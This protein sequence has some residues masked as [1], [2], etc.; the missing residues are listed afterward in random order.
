[1]KKERQDNGH[2][3]KDKQQSTNTTQKIKDRIFKFSSAL[4]QHAS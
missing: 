4:D 1:M 3:K 2:T